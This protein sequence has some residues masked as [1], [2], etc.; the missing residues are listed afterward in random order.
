MMMMMMTTMKRD[1]RDE[2]RER[3][4]D[5]IDEITYTSLPFPSPSYINS[6]Y[7]IKK[8]FLI[9]D[10]SYLYCLTAYQPE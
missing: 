5:E 9:F 8:L 4:I 1:E 6:C 7:S 2:E 10:F 3:E